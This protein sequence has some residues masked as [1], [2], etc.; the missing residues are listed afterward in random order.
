MNLLHLVQDTFRQALS[1]YAADVERAVHMIKPTQDAKHGDYQANCAM[2]L[3][4]EL[5]KKPRD[6]AQEIVDRLPLGAVFD[7]PEIAGP[8]FINL[9]LRNDWIAEHVQAMAKDD[10][11]GVSPAKPARTYVIDYSSPNVAKPMHVGH[12]RS[13]II[14]DSMARLLRFLG[15]KVIADNHLGDWGTQFGI[16]LYG[17]K[18]L[19]DRAALARDPVAEMLRLYIAVRNL[20]KPIEQEEDEEDEGEG[21]AA[22][23][24]QATPEQIATA[25]QV[26]DTARQETAK[27]HSG[28]PENLQ[29]WKQIMPWCLEVNE[30]IYRRLDVHFDCTHGES[31]YNPMLADVVDDLL[32]KRIAEESKGAIAIFFSAGQSP[33]LVRK[34]DGAYTYTTSDLA[35]IRYRVETWQP[36]A[37]LYVVDSRQ[38]LHFQNLFAAARRWGYDKVALEHVSF[39]SVLGEDRK[40]LKTREGGVIELNALL[41]EGVEQAV[42]VFEKTRQEEAERGDDAGELTA[43]ERRGIA[44]AVGVGAIKYADLCQNRQTDYIFSWPKMLAMN[45]NTGTYM[46]YAYVRNRGIF[47]KGGIDPTALRTD[48]PRPSLETAHERALALALLRFEEALDA[49]ATEYQANAI[50]SYLWDLSK[51]YSGFFQNC[52][53]LK[54]PT[55]DLR[56][57]RLLLCDLTARVIQRGLD[58]LGIRTV[59]R[60]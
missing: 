51:S 41:D 49:A 47:R 50:T 7:K 20:I 56:Q 8:G 57:S 16:L 29:L 37:I 28:D 31:F 32:K 15:H 52:P 26:R 27:L 33:A 1:G 48:P 11:L 39:G 44:E 6:V 13:T 9:R 38:A 46:Q 4:K 25:S 60:M 24:V 3:A 2:S 59:E 45:G 21:D 22:G 17:Y 36:D 30:R 55:E 23:A 43:Q 54:A 40:P 34:N 58:L 5:G 10:R 42:E 19:L 35:T 14:G 18:H 12:L 53:V